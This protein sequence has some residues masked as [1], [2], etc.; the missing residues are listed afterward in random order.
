MNTLSLSEQRVQ[1]ITWVLMCLLPIN[2]MTVDLVAPSLPAIA[3]SLAVSAALIKS[4]I[5]VYLIGYAL[6]NFITGFLTDAFGRRKFLLLGILGFTL[7]SALPIVFPNIEV[8]LLARFLQG[9]TMGG[10]AVVNR[11]IFSDILPANK[12]VRLGTMIGTMWGIGPVVGPIIGGYLQVYYGWQSCFL[13]FV[14]TMALCGVLAYVIVP[15]T[16]FNRQSLNIN[17]IRKNC[18]EVLSNK[19]FMGLVLIMGLVYALIIAFNTL[20]PFLIEDLFHHTP[21]FFGHISL[22]MGL[23]FLAAT[24]ICRYLLTIYDSKLLFIIIINLFFM[25][26][27][28][29]MIFSYGLR[30]NLTFIV[31]ISVAM[32]FVSGIIFPMSMGTG[33][34]LFRRIAG[35]AVAIM[36]LINILLTSLVNFMIS[37]LH[38]DSA[39]PLM[40][41]YLILMALS[42]L[43]YWFFIHEPLK[44][45]CAIR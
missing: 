44:S 36:Y 22:G 28:V 14:L 5:S 11:A 37:F 39:V 18:V 29:A 17:T 33:L 10:I 24:F 30:Y 1:M 8:L 43:V 40:W 12:L 42:M 3:V 34:L 20:G 21:I 25:L 16:H 15:E 19:L 32:Y 38:L 45:E 7:V 13:F 6:G 2:G 23:V 27:I 41:V 4:V 26:A 31:A 9:L 35:T